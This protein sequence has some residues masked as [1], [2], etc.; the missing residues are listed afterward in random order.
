METEKFKLKKIRSIAEIQRYEEL[1]EVEQIMSKGGNGYS[2]GLTIA[3]MVSAILFHF[4]GCGSGG[5]NSGDNSNNNI[6]QQGGNSPVVIV[7]SSG[8]FNQNEILINYNVGS[9]SHS[10]VLYGFT[11]DSIRLPDNT[12]LYNAVADTFVIN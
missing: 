3:E 12:M 4:N 2:I 10:M 9:V 5:G 1:S 11:A 8:F 6:L 7:S